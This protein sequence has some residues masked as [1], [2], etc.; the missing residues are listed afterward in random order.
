MVADHYLSEFAPKL[1]PD[2]TMK[3]GLDVSCVQDNSRGAWGVW[4]FRKIGKYVM[5][6]LQRSYVGV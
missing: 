5:F 2:H 6:S 4:L 3:F 1:Q